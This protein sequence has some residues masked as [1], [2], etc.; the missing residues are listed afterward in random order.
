[1]VSQLAL[2]QNIFAKFRKSF[3][4]A[5]RKILCLFVKNFLASQEKIGGNTKNEHFHV[6]SNGI[7]IRE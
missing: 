1:M 3:N 6:N 5:T 2:V 4:F 7:H